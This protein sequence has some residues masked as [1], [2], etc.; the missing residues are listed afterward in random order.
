MN[1][2]ISVLLLIGLLTISLSA[3]DTTTYYIL[4]HSHALY[5]ID[6]NLKK[7][8]ISGL[9][10]I[11]PYLDSDKDVMEGLGHHIINT[12]EGKI[13]R[14]II[15]E[16]CIFLDSEIRIDEHTTSDE[17]SAFLLKN[18]SKIHF[19]PLAEAFLITPLS[20]RNVKARFRE[21]SDYKK[22][23][24]KHK[25]PELLATDW[26][27]KAGIDKLIEEKD[28]KA[29]LLI[30]SELYKIRYRFN[31]HHFNEHEY[32]E[33][34]EFLT[35]KEI[36]VKNHKE[37]FTWHIEKMFEPDA[38]LNLLI[39][40]SSNYS[41]FKWNEEKATYENKNIIAKSIDIEEYF[42]QRLNDENDSIA[43][44]A[45]IQ[46]TTGNPEKVLTISKEYRRN[47]IDNNYALPT[48]P[49]RFLD[50]MVFMTQ[51]CRDHDIDFV[52]NKVLE[53]IIQEL[54]SDKSFSERRQLED[55]L[56]N[57]L[58]LEDITAFEYWALV[59]EN[60]WDLTHSAG[61][62]LDGF[63]S[64]NWDKLLNNPKHLALYLKKSHWFDNL[65][66]IGNCNKYLI[67]F[68]NN[69][70]KGISKLKALESKDVE[71]NT[72]L[73][74]AIVLCSNPI[75]TPNDTM[76][77]NIA[78]MD[79]TVIDLR[80]KIRAIKLLQ[81]DEQREDSL[82][83]ILSQINYSQIGIALRDIEDLPFTEY[84]WRKYSFMKRDWGLFMT[85]DFDKKLTRKEFLDLYDKLSEYE[86][87]THYLKKAKIDYKKKDDSLDYDKIY[88]ILKYNI[89][90]AFVGGGGGEMDNEVY[91]II[92][93][94]ELTHKTTL[95]YPEKL[96]NSRGIY[97]CDS[98]DRAREWRHYLK[99]NELLKKDHREPVSFKY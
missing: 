23:E 84:K 96:C 53:V 35:N 58:T 12:N 5:P 72:Q 34:L 40:F 79:D 97:G 68:T 42:F 90:K 45:F 29:L 3:Q 31:I 36:A 7:G 87:Y 22:E 54:R 67:K 93:I 38:S 51:Y 8:E 28:P 6:N 80:D 78:N 44:Q 76:K 21:L 14:R 48:F 92:K 11:A 85:G 95:G 37:E 73:N 63:Y 32:L 86:L 1:K 19:D 57:S 4:N 20:K 59:Y 75:K 71:I 17:F 55:Q 89:V 64:K 27:K 61:R 88:D 25:L 24:I 60:S 74:R 10:E 94:L 52:G 83:E 91:M 30:A 46:L 99:E 56:I 47:D 13:A 33:L 41:K 16:N 65:G 18:K 50:Q 15:D 62:I 2:W 77:I 70:E 49:Y 82:V 66:I 9:F 26:V 69:G 98:M 81:D 39:Y 43:I